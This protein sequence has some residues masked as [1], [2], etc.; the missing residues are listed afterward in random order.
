M[1]TQNF[2]LSGSKVFVTGVVYNDTVVN[3][4]F[5]SVGEQTVGRGI[6]GPGGVSDVTGAGGGYE[7]AFTAG[8]GKAITFSLATGAVGVSVTVGTTNVKVDVVNGRE[9][10]PTRLARE[11][12]LPK[13]RRALG[14]RWRSRSHVRQ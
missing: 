12:R 14:S 13:S 10:G 1:V 5:F 4:N 6:S 7:L 8:G 2:A 9:C 11:R 3:D